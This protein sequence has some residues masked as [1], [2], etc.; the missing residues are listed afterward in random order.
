MWTSY[1]GLA[2]IMLHQGKFAEAESLD[3]KLLTLEVSR[4]RVEEEPHTV[5][6]LQQ[7]CGHPGS[8]GKYA[9]VE[10]TADSLFRLAQDTRRRPQHVRHSAE[11]WRSLSIPK[12]STP[13]R[14]PSAVG[15]LAIRLNTL[16][17]EHRLTAENYTTLA[18][19]LDQQGKGRRGLKDSPPQ[20]AGD[21]A[22]DAGQETPG[23]R[24]RLRLPHLQPGCGETPR[25]CRGLDSGCC[26]RRA[27]PLPEGLRAGAVAVDE[28][29]AL[30]RAD[31]CSGPARAKPA[32]HGT[33]GRPAWRWSTRRPLRP[34][35]LRPLKADRRRHRSRPSRPAQGAR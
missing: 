11:I 23:H 19:S 14:R 30:R 4:H 33:A 25:S 21:L 5:Q 26:D 32:K 15:A 35:S 22:Q 20:G 2:G 17:E 31:R 12:G 13:E 9:E 28:V 18:N 24:Q 16:G 34:S 3:R 8:T 10:C 29:Y 27:L 1:N 7:F 6:N